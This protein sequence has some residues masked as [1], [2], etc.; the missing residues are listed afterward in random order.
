MV[1]TL[2]PFYNLRLPIIAIHDFVTD[3]CPVGL[4]PTSTVLE[5][6]MLPLHQG[7]KKWTTDRSNPCINILTTISISPHLTRSLNIQSL[8]SK[9]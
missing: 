6:A 1:F 4:E 7:H 8:N 9:T 5:T 2:C 3:T